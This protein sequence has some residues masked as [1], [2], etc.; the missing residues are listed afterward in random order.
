MHVT[1]FNRDPSTFTYL[2]QRIFLFDDIDAN[3]NESRLK[4]LK[5]FS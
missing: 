2:I 4:S 1:I 3:S 5:T